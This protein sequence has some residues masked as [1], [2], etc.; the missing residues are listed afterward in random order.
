MSPV[1]YTILAVLVLIT[2]LNLVLFYQARTKSILP[3][4]P[5]GLLSYAGLLRGSDIDGMVTEV[6][7]KP[8]FD[9]QLTKAVKEVYDLKGSSCKLEGGASSKQKIA[10]K[11]LVKRQPQP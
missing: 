5:S 6:M 9:G 4:E 11:N 10:M 3:E 8:G 1:A 2:V 7:R